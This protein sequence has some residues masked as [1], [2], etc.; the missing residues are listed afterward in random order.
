MRHI[1]VA[2]AAGGVEGMIEEALI[3]GRIRQLR[4]ER[5]MTQEILA[6]AAGMTKGYLS[7]IENSRHSPPVS[8]LV[9]LAKALG[10]GIESIF[11]EEAVA[12]D[13]T[14]LRKDERQAIALKGSSFGYSYEPLALKYPN[15]HMDPYIMTMPP[16]V[17][18]TVEFAHKGE[19]LLFMLEGRGEMQLGEHSIVLEEGDC[20]YF[21]STIPHSGRSLS[22]GGAKYLVV[23]FSPD[24]PEEPA[25][26]G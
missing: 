9:K 3:G 10:V 26:E 14:L 22:E 6:Q 11:S 2:A 25:D 24:G 1:P 12:T 23:L 13:F 18:G 15:R 7:K 20:V 8:T 4:H 5:N 19:E 17:E 21:N 16:G